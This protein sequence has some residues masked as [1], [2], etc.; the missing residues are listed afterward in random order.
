MPVRKLNVERRVFGTVNG[1]EEYHCHYVVG[2]GD[3]AKPAWFTVADVIQSASETPGAP[4]E[5]TI[6]SCIGALQL[7]GRALAGASG[8]NDERAQL[9]TSDGTTF[10]VRF[11]DVP[12][13]GNSPPPVD[14]TIAEVAGSPGAPSEEDFAAVA[15]FFM[16]FGDSAA[17]YS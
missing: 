9:A 15:A 14:Y 16:S 17:G 1:A 2:E 11:R 6:T 4:D 10:A 3:A 13:T 8:D 5:A 12:P 7:Y